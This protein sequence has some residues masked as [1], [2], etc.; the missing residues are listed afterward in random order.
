VEKK[1]DNKY[2]IINDNLKNDFEQ[3]I[4]ENNDTIKIQENQIKNLESKLDNINC[5]LIKND[6]INKEK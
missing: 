2:K 1:T 3:K 5:I 4:E 6:E